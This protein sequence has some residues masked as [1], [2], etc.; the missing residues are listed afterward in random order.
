MQGSDPAT[1]LTLAGLEIILSGDNAVVLAALAQVLPEREQKRALFYGILGAFILRFLAILSAKWIIRFWFLQVGGGAYLI[2]LAIR[3]LIGRQEKG[4]SSPRRGFARGFWGVVLVIELTDLA[5][6]VDSVLAAVAM[7]P[8]IWVIYSGAMIG[9]VAMRFA[10]TAVLAVLKKFPQ[11]TAYAYALVGWI[12]LKLVFQGLHGQAVGKYLQM[13]AVEFWV[14][15]VLIMLTAVV[16]GLRAGCKAEPE[17][18][19]SLPK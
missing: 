15:T 16:H 18:S 13:S 12:G 2:W 19:G 5:F 6:A 3:H 14:V 8:K 4:P 9:L 11:L 10:A 7:S 17:N 1:I